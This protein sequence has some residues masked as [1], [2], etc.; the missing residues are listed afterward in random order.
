MAEAIAL[1]YAGKSKR[2]YMLQ[3]IEHGDR[4]EEPRPPSVPVYGY[5]VAYEWVLYRRSLTSLLSLWPIPK[6]R[7]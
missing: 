1:S 2:R 7:R 3:G 4:E 6:R 5:S